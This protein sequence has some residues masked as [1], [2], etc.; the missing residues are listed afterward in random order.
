[1]NATSQDIASLLEGDSSGSGLGLTY[2]VN[3]FIG[4][5]P[6]KPN[7]C[8]TIFDTGGMPPQMNLTDQGYE[9]PSI[10]IRVRSSDYLTGWD[11]IEAIKTFLHGRGQ[12]TIDG[13]FYSAISCASGPAF[14]DWD[15][16]SRA[17]FVVNFSI[18]RRTN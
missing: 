8:T 13:T 12:E 11:M 15:E 4:K 14:L 6:S 1:M 7:D 10:Q 16:N 5:E 3:L 9:F 2:A 17:R 18:Q